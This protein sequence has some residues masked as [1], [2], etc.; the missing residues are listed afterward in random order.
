MALSSE[1]FSRKLDE[2]EDE[3]KCGHSNWNR[4]I[5]HTSDGRIQ[6]VKQ[7]KKCGLQ[8]GGAE[9]QRGIDISNLDLPLW[10]GNLHSNF[11]EQKRIR[12]AMLQDANNGQWH[13]QYETYLQSEQWKNLRRLVL[14]RDDYTCQNCFCQVDESANIHHLSYQGYNTHGF[15]FAWECITLCRK[16]HA[17]WH[18]KEERES[19]EMAGL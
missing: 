5:K 13:K 4:C 2:I 14:A 17:A 8:V 15:S 18:G 10:N 7:C 9:S 1:E 12:I 3:F 6:I 19:F 11:L 16:C